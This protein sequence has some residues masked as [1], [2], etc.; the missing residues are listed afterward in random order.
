M[1]V[2]LPTLGRQLDWIARH[3]QIVSLEEAFRSEGRPRAAITF[4]DGYR[5]VLE[6]GLPLLRQ[7]GIPAAVFVVTDCLENGVLLHDRVRRIFEHGGGEIF[8]AA[9]PF[10]ENLPEAT[11]IV[12]EK[13]P[14]ADLL[15][16]VEEAERHVLFE[17][18]CPA[19]MNRADLLT[20]AAAGWTIGSHGCTHAV[21]P[22][23]SP[24]TQ[25]EEALRS[26]L[27]LEVAMGKPITHFA[28]PCGRFDSTSVAAVDAAG[29]AFAYST[30]RH[31][32]RK[33]PMLSVPR[34]M[35]WE[36]STRTGSGGYSASFLA[37]HAAGVL[38]SSCSGHTP[39]PP[40]AT[41]DRVPKPSRPSMLAP[42]L[43]LTISRAIGTVVTLA[44]PA[45]LAR[46]LD[47]DEFGTYR[48]L[49]LLAGTV[50]A[51][52]Q[53]GMAESLY[54]FLP[55]GSRGMAVNSLL[56][57]AGC[58]IVSG[59]LLTKGAPALAGWMDNERLAITLP[60]L[61]PFVA[62][63]LPAALLE[64][65]LCA[66][67]RFATVAIVTLVS[68]VL[69]AALL[70]VPVLLVGSLASLLLGAAAFAACRLSAAVVLLRRQEGVSPDR[71]QLREQLGYALP[72]GLSVAVDTAQGYWHQYAVSHLLGPFTFASY[73]AG[74]SQLPLADQAA[75]AAGNVLMVRTGEATEKA[76]ALWRETVVSLAWML[77]PLAALPLLF[78][79]EIVEILY[80]ARYL[81]AVPVYRIAALSVLLYIFPTDAALR[82]AGATRTLLGLATMRLALIVPCVGLAITRFGTSGAIAATV[83]IA[84]LAKL[85]AGY[86][87]ARRIGV[88]PLTL[89]PARSLV[90]IVAAAGIASLAGLEMRNICMPLP[91]A[92]RAASAAAAFFVVFAGAG[93]IATGRIPHLR[94]LKGAT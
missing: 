50:L 63:M 56:F 36:G 11:R 72:Y 27:A 58:G 69:R 61:A 87:V 35:L 29:Y 71:R 88:S 73:S 42:T 32:D 54:Y 75:T 67:G 17:R 31:R 92:L 25:A 68:D 24:S 7:K 89:F 44:I 76:V 57:L 48:Q 74:V 13:V 78:A 23:E 59:L 93:L 15:P 9:G 40:A 81:D 43:Q 38:G 26:R 21:L 46:V 47:R 45:V 94:L 16:L 62:L 41:K 34:A 2:S 5:D 28:Y 18:P 65:L 90:P 77:V 82:A 20:L 39:P 53:I 37:A 19:L 49:F 10:P 91:L 33:R 51:V 14:R 84:G 66:R 60:L 80:T 70:V 22:S 4:D 3:Y 30:C 6:L 79:R 86:V 12:V 64:P 8:A 1:S 83:I 52:G 55:R 85:V